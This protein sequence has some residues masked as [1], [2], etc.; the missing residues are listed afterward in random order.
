MVFHDQGINMADINI[1]QKH[2][3]RNPS[4]NAERLI[5]FTTVHN[6]L[7]PQH[8]LQQANGVDSLSA[9]AIKAEDIIAQYF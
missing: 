6:E 7:I 9:A 4:S 8:H 5:G 3:R 2:T 1:R